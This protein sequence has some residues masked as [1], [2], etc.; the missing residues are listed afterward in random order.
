[1]TLNKKHCLTLLV[2]MLVLLLGAGIVSAS[3][4]NDT[5]QVI[6]DNNKL[7]APSNYD[8]DNVVQSDLTIVNSDA[9]V[10]KISNTSENTKTIKTNKQTANSEKTSDSNIIKN[11]INDDIE[12]TIKGDGED[13][14][15]SLQQ[16][17]NENTIIDLT[18]TT[19]SRRE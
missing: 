19:S 16:L 10:E 14:F 6:K 15:T 8:V 9:D 11:N 3:D 4:T 1:M 17:I 7:S 5:S 12:K 2:I 13:S 18:T